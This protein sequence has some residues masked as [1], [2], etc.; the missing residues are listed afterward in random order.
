MLGFALSSNLL[1]GIDWNWPKPSSVCPYSNLTSLTNW[2]GKASSLS[3][4]L[5]DIPTILTRLLI[6]WWRQWAP[7][8]RRSISARLHSAVSWKT[9]Y[10]DWNCL[11]TFLSNIASTTLSN[12]QGSSKKCDTVLRVNKGLLQLKSVFSRSLLL[13]DIGTRAITVF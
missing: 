7:L 6:A 9:D 3:D 11:S 5:L 4:P 2:S 10:L 12:I 8:K 1:L 13:H